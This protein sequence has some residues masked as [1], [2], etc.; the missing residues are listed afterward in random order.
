MTAEI[1]LKGIVL[2]VFPQGE[3]GRRAVIL[4][5]KLGKITVFSAGAA[6]PGSGLVGTLTPFTCAVFNIAKGR[7]A[8][9]LRSIEV[10]DA[11]DGLSSDAEAAIYGFYVLELA[12]YFS[13]EGM[14][15][16]EAK[17][18]LNLIFV[19]LLA[20]GKAELDNEIIRRIYELRLLVLQGEYTTEPA[21]KSSALGSADKTT[22]ILWHH[23]ISARLSELYELKKNGIEPDGIK[24]FTD[25]VSLLFDKQVHHSFKSLGIL[26]DFL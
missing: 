22:E 21:F 1:S 25:S 6:K 24:R 15:E 4:T 16:D 19:T 11:F 17:T 7:S 3:Y 12:E 18:L 23:T 8:Y 14:N 10:I 26:S 2:K 13:I 9:N 5:D 20:I